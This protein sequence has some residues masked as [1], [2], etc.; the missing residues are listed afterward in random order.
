MAGVIASLI[1][2]YLLSELFAILLASSSFDRGKPLHKKLKTSIWFASCL[3]DS[4]HTFFGFARGLVPEPL[5]H[6]DKSAL[7]ASVFYL[8]CRADLLLTSQKK[9]NEVVLDVFFDS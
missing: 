8:R 7:M 4:V 3:G 9:Q 5:D 2:A 6:A 1:P